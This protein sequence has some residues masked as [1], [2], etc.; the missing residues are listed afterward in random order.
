MKT[1]EMPTEDDATLIVRS[2]LSLEPTSVRRFSEGSCHFVFAVETGNDRKVVVRL[3]SPSTQRFLEGGVY[4]AKL[5]RPLGVPLPKVL[6]REFFPSDIRFPFVILEHVEGADLGAIYRTLSSAEKFQLATDV[7]RIQ[8]SVCSL[9]NA[10]GFGFAFSYEEP[11]TFRRWENVL[12]SFLRRAD[13]RMQRLERH[14][15]R[16]Y[17]E[18]ASRALAR[19]ESYF[20]SVQPTP[21]LDDMTTKNVLVSGGRLTGIVDVDQ[22]CFGDPLLTVGLTQMALLAASLDLEY[23]EHWMNL[24]SLTEQQRKIA[25]AYTLLFCIDFMGE[26]GQRFNRPETASIDFDKLSHLAT[27]F[28]GLAN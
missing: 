9:P 18:R 7:S 2:R 26:L 24:L 15:G 1:P 27:L 25:E 19:H 22:L 10:Q 6:W 11:P 16:A 3:S 12:S 23:T 8:Q 20:S 4:W 28:E 13:E 14:P 21:F 17:V 5:L